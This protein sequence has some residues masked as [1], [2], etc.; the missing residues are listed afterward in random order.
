[1]KIVVMCW[2]A[3]ASVDVFV[4]H[5]IVL[6]PDLAAKAP[7]RVAAEL[8]ALAPDVVI[9]RESQLEAVAAIAAGFTACRFVF[10]G[11]AASRTAVDLPA[12]GARCAFVAGSTWER[13]EYEA[14]LLAESMCRPKQQH[15][16]RPEACAHATGEVMLVGAGVVNLVTALTLCRRG[17][18]VSVFDRMADP[19]GQGEPHP[20]N[21]GATFGGRDARIF[22]YN[23][24]RH[25]LA[26]SP[27]YTPHDTPRFRLGIAQDGWLSRRYETLSD[28][29]RRW[30][31]QLE[32]VPPWAA[33]QYDNDIVG[34]NRQSHRLWHEVFSLHP[35]LLRETHHVGRL[36]RIYPSDA[37]LCAAQTAEAEIGALID[38]VP[39]PRLREREPALADAIDGGAIAGALEVHGFSLNIV[40]FCRNLIALLE[41]LGVRF[42]WQQEAGEVRQTDSGAVTGIVVNGTLRRSDHYVLSPGAQARTLAARTTGLPAIGAMVGMWVTLPNDGAPLRSP[43]KVR[44]RA[45]GSQEA[46]QGANVVP[47]RD[48]AGRPVLH[49]SSG[50]GFVGASADD[51]RLAD[52]PELSRCVMET[53]EEL[54]GDKFGRARQAGMLGERP[55]FCV[56]PWTPSGLG[57]LE[58]QETDTGGRLVLSGGHNT[59]GFAQSPAVAEAVA[60]ALE[61]RAHAMHT[62]YHPRRFADVF[63]VAS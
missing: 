53:A 32:Q 43:L 33:L 35:E 44:R 59:G 30:I 27:L 26:C 31:A 22:S 42:H 23:E 16:P 58:V 6:R 55:G 41:S 38:T 9:A 48:A 61:A 7:H 18:R 1:M 20:A 56:R 45:F 37:S 54:F 10:C 47:G 24:S 3:K 49:C 19:R 52:L 46:A 57:V 12:L 5:N 40:S 13:A 15:A 8:S 51:V 2:L 11:L 25:H 60:C 36:L 63:E 39:R 17:H 21:A 62:L 50:H 4:A 34:F 28:A 14:F 29:D